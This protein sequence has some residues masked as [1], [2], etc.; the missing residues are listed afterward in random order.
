MASTQTETVYGRS[1]SSAG[2]EE[3]PDTLLAYNEPCIGPYTHTSS[4]LPQNYFFIIRFP[5]YVEF[6][7][8][9]LGSS[10]DRFPPTLIERQDVHARNP[11]RQ[12][13][14]M[15]VFLSARNGPALHDMVQFLV[16]IGVGDPLVGNLG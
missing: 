15:K 6:N 16:R 3:A 2:T 14:I 10:C 9:S 11:K 5:K 8:K 7:E 4:A 12:E 13:Q 1:W